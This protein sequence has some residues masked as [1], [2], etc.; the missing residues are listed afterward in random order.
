[1]DAA[2]GDTE[3]LSDRY[4]LAEFSQPYVESGLVMIVTVNKSK[5]T[6][7]F[8][9]SFTMRM[10]LTMAAMHMFVGFVIW[11]IER[12]ENPDLK[13]YGAMLWFSITVLFFAQSKF[14]VVLKLHYHLY[15]F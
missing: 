9:K 15:G 3:I 10:W 5:E 2:V 14:L 1:M 12:E 8:M 4:Q 13:S 6:W 11:L 7:M